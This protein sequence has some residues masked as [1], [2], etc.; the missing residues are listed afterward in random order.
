[1]SLTI[2]CDHDITIDDDEIIEETLTNLR[3][4]IINELI[5]NHYDELLLKMQRHHNIQFNILN[6][7]DLAV[8]K[9]IA[10]DYYRGSFNLKLIIS[11]IGLEEV[12]KII[13]QLELN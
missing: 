8:R 2:T 10:V 13:Y 11:E 7:V 4:D 9:E 12:K 3:P 5:N 1:M 6:T